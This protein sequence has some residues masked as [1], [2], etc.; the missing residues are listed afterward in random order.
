MHTQGIRVSALALLALSL[1][2]FGS[3][4]TFQGGIRGTVTDATGAV[5][6]DAKVTLTDI[7]TGSSRST[8]SGN[9]GEYTFAAL[10]PAT[11]TIVVQ[12]PGFKLLEQKGIVVSTQEYLIADL[13]MAVGEVTQSVN[14]EAAVPL[15]EAD[16]ASTGQV[17]DT[18]KLAD[19]PNM[20]RNPFYEGVKISQN[21]TPGGNPQF[22]RMEDQSGSSQI[23]IAGGPVRGN[24]YLLDGISV[25]DSTNRAVIIP[26]VE[27]VQELKLQANTYDAEVGRTGGGTFNLFLKSGTNNYHAA[28]FGYSWFQPWL[29]NTYFGNAAGRNADGSL[30][31]PIADQPFFNYGGAIGGPLSIP[32]VYNAKN[33]TFFYITGEAYRQQKPSST[34]LAVPTA[35]ERIGDFSQS[36]T[37]SGA[38][39]TIYDPTT[40]PRVPFPNNIIPQNALSPVGLAMASYYYYV[41]Y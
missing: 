14:V 33:R 16:T 17:I 22:N 37:S 26:T 11:Y 5:I 21:V 32:K 29:A 20:G 34:V 25:T 30:K 18:Q 3:A 9:G 12:K 13:K 19:L 27:S 23:S 24:N 10:N 36:R 4:Q 38:L 8:L 1:G 31:S 35:Q 2:S 15:I 41:K 39:Q 28:A 7:G 40:N 6:A